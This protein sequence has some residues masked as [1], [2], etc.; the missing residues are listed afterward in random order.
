MCRFSVSINN[1]VLFRL[2]NWWLFVMCLCE[3]VLLE[4]CIIVSGFMQLLSIFGVL[5]YV[6][7]FF[8]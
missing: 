8:I 5:G 7:C 3:V 6:L 2:V 4:I 1:T